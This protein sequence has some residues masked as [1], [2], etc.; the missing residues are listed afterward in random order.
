MENVCFEMKILSEKKLSLLK[1]YNRI[2]IHEPEPVYLTPNFTSGSG[3]ATVTAQ[4]YETIVST[5]NQKG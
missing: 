4:M 2:R 1:D 5:A 3:E